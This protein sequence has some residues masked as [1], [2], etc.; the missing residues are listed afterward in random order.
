[1]SETHAEREVTLLEPTNHESLIADVLSDQSAEIIFPSVD[2]DPLSRAIIITV[3]SSNSTT[4]KDCNA[5]LQSTN[6]NTGFGSDSEARIHSGSEVQRPDLN[7][8]LSGEV[9]QAPSGLDAST[10]ASPRIDSNLAAEFLTNSMKT[11]HF[12]LR[13]QETIKKPYIPAVLLNLLTTGNS[14][15]EI[16]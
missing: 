8:A 9:C 6:F 10:G 14:S 11:D 12:S 15:G 7:L 4:P 13:T 5:L 16:K 1:M 2:I 3:S